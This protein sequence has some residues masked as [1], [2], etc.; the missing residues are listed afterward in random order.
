MINHPLFNLE[1]DDLDPKRA[2]EKRGRDIVYVNI[3]QLNGGKWSSLTNQWAPEELLTVGALYEAVGNVDGQYE[4]IGRGHKNEVIDRQMHVL[5]GPRGSAA[6]AAPAP[7]PAAPSG[8]PAMVP[9]QAGSLVIPANMD[10]NMAMV[11][12]MMT[13]QSQQNQ[14]AQQA[15]LAQ[16]Q[17]SAELQMQ[18]QQFQS[19]QATAQH[20]ANMQMLT[21]L[22][23][24]I[25]PALTTHAA[26]G[27]G[28]AG[29]AEIAQQAFL[30]GVETLL[31]FKKGVDESTS[32]GKTDWNVISANIANGFKSLSEVVKTT[33]GPT[34]PA[35][36]V[37]PPGGTGQ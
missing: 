5:K 12:S 7:A 36:P 32:G 26:G 30:K 20:Q 16:A 2:Q 28:G 35:P 1:T 8:P 27:A 13:L 31:D 34:T 29:G 9:M 14:Q 15:Q 22:A 33:V 19:Q 4:L 17:R 25:V 23:T 21:G 11:I 24:V 18:Q 37:V 10:P 3:R 6:Q